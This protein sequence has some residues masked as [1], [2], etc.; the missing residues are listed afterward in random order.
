MVASFDLFSSNLYW[1]A[2]RR[3]RLVDNSQATLKNLWELHRKKNFDVKN[4]LRQEMRPM[5]SETS[6]PDITN[7]NNKI[8]K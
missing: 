8:D 1:R 6:L 4:F 2:S 7:L 3:T 5:P